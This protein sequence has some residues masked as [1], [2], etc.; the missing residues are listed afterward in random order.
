MARPE[1]V[2]GV[3]DYLSHSADSKLFYPE[4]E[5]I[6]LDGAKTFVFRPEFPEYEDCVDP[7][8]FWYSATQRPNLSSKG[9]Q[10]NNQQ[11]SSKRPIRKR[12]L[13]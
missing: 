4:I 5:N 11:P 12:T 1:P 6:N 2:A 3:D 7:I 13:T 10:E 8:L 9:T